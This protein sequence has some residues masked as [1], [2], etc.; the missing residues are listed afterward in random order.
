ML[1]FASLLKKGIL[2]REIHCQSV[3]END[4]NYTTRKQRKNRDNTSGQ[5]Q[6]KFYS[7]LPGLPVCMFV[8]SQHTITIVY[9]AGDER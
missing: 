7:M 2:R 5:L 4:Q 1:A 3:E 9:E 6:S 8:L